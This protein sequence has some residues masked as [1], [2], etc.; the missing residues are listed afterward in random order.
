MPIAID[1]DKVLPTQSTL[2][3][4]R[5]DAEGLPSC[6][7]FMVPPVIRH[8]IEIEETE[9]FALK[10]I[11]PADI[12]PL[13]PQDLLADSSFLPENTIVKNSGVN[14]LQS[15]KE[16]NAVKFVKQVK[17][18]VSCPHQDT[19]FRL[20]TNYLTVLNLLQK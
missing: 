6:F 2:I 3:Q 1:L 12:A 17:K 14:L 18:C 8:T 13:S 9:L 19:C 20:T 4:E 7:G 10:N 5:L 11:N 16:K 15:I